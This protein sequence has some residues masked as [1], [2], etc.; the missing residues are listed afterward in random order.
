MSLIF[1]KGA[2]LYCSLL[3]SFRQVEP[4]ISTWSAILLRASPDPI[5]P[6][7]L[8]A[9]PDFHHHLHGGFHRRFRRANLGALL[10]TFHKLSVSM[11]REHPI[12]VKDQVVVVSA[13]LA[14]IGLEK[15]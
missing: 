13:C 4:E 12:A 11:S 10:L 2:L 5:R 3:Q 6:A 14:S 7:A 9:Q 1:T 15:G 8:L